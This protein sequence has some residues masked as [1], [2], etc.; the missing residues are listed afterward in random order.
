LEQQAAAL[1][2]VPYF[3]L[4]FTLP[5]E[6]NP[7]IRQNQR[8]L[9]RLLF[10]AASQTLLEFG[11]NRLRAQVGITAV[12]H[13]WSQTLLDH[14]HLHAIVTGGGL[15]DGGT[16][17]ASAPAHYLFPVRALSVVFRGK[18]CAGLQWLY[19]GGQLEFHGQLAPRAAQPRFQALLREATRRPWVVY[20]KRPFAGPHQVLAYLSRYTH[21]VAIRPRRLRH[22]D[23]RA[24]TVTFGWR[25]YADGARSKTMTLGVGEFVRR[26]CLHLLPQGF[27]KIR[28]FGFLSNRQRQTR[29]AQARTLLQPV[30]PTASGVSEPSSAAS[31]ESEAPPGVVCPY[32]GSRRLQLIEIVPARCR[33][34]LAPTLDSS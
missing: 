23:P 12:L 4:V 33:L 31:C 9:Y 19:A 17:W 24:Q 27:V 34:G 2:P 20:A 7:L 21:R 13:T 26:F 18:F 30:A 22:L 11:Q 14:Y 28:H 3:H 25:D 15:A 10:A 29:V 5:H 8:V 16:R 1:L 32:C 6:L